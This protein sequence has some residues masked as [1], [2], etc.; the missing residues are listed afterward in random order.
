MADRRCKIFSRWTIVSLLVSLMIAQGVCLDKYFY[1]YYKQD[2]WKFFICAYLPAVVLLL[3]QQWVETLN[4]DSVLSTEKEEVDGSSITWFKTLKRLI[5]GYH[6]MFT[7]LLYV[8]PSI[9]QYVW[10]LSTFA[11]DIESS[12][13]ALAQDSSE[14]YCAFLLECFCCWTQ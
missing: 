9:V 10:I 5:T 8:V 14:S 6:K 4:D 3:W 7:W 13:S 12:S 11:D 1:N 2:G